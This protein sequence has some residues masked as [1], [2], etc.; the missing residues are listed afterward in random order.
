VRRAVAASPIENVVLIVDSYEDVEAARKHLGM[1]AIV[2]DPPDHMDFRILGRANFGMVV[3][4]YDAS[5]RALSIKNVFG[6]PRIM[7][8]SLDGLTLQWM[9]EHRDLNLKLK[10]RKPYCLSVRCVS[11]RRLTARRKSETRQPDGLP[12][13][14]SRAPDER[15]FYVAGGLPEKL[16]RLNGKRP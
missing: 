14:S 6:L 5:M 11:S 9:A 12:R 16:T 10:I 1:K 13:A 7:F 2:F 4:A 15:R 3:S 8:V